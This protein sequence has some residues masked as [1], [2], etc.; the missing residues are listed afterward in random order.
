VSEQP[1][2]T[3]REVDGE[4]VLDDPDALGAIKAV[5]KHN[6]R[7]TLEGQADRVA[8]FKARAIAR[9]VDTCVIVLLNVDEPFGRELTDV[10]MPGQEPTWQAIRDSGQI[11]YARGLAGRAG[12]VDFAADMDPEVGKKLEALAGKVAVLV[13][14]HGWLE[15]F[16]AP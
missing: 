14:D 11:P 12:I 3:V 13:V 15:A 4:L 16:E 10:L 5:A 1:R 9:G 6:C 8:H 2:A 7:L